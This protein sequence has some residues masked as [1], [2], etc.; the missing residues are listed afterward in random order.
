MRLN[1][2]S[3]LAG[4]LLSGCIIVGDMPKGTWDDTGA[5]EF[6][7]GEGEGEPVT[8]IHI[9]PEQLEMGRKDAFMVTTEPA[10]EYELVSDVFALDGAEVLGFQPTDEALVVTIGAPEGSEP[11]PITLILEY[12][13]GTIEV[14]KEAITVVDPA[15]ELEEGDTGAP[16]NQTP[17]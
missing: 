3:L 7:E 17:E 1:H 10:I 12:A 15:A 14:A 6:E 16:E 2:L 4:S 5:S 13:D 9:T 8:T 11:G